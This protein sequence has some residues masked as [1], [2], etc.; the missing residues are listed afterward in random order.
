VEHREELPRVQVWPAGQARLPL[1]GDSI[2]AR[3]AV[4]FADLAVSRRAGA[5]PAGR[6]A[7]SCCGLEVYLARI[8]RGPAA[9]V[10][11]RSQADLCLDGPGHAEPG[12]R[13]MRGAGR[14]EYLLSTAAWADCV[15]GVHI[16]GS[17]HRRVSPTTTH[18]AAVGDVDSLRERP[19]LATHHDQLLAA[20]FPCLCTAR[21]PD[22]C[23]SR[24]R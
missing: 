24:F 20:Y 11:G 22:S 18:F 12:Q 15:S 13:L 21:W 23:P 19:P 7:R 5:R 9:G 17:A 6:E 10:P 3:L 1:Q 2:D 16:F 14:A 4:V 8:W